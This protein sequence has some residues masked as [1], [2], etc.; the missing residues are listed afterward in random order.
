MQQRA[1]IP[2]VS[3]PA[4][5][6]AMPTNLNDVP[7]YINYLRAAANV[8][9]VTFD[10]TLDDN[11]WQHSRYMAEENVIA[12]D[13]NTNSRWFSAAGQ[14]CAK[15]GNIWLG[16]EVLSAVLGTGQQRRRLDRLSGSPH[17]VAL[18]DDI[19]LRIWVL[20]GNK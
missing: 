1:F 2:M 18:S 20:L 15:N 4:A 7:A 8:P 3:R 13:E 12:H 11:C 14:A 6:L 19:Y 16:G 10:S 5:A 17:V 9:L